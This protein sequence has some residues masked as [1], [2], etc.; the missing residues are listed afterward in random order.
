MK[1]ILFFTILHFG[2][3]TLNCFSQSKPAVVNT[4]IDSI[5]KLLLTAQSDTLKANAFVALSE[6]L[7]LSKID[8]VLPL[9]LKAIKISD[10]KLPK[11]DDAEKKSFLTAK[12]N[13]LNNMGYVYKEQGNIPK[14]LELY[15][16]SLKLREEIGDK[17]G[18]ANSLNNIGRIYNNRGDIPSALDCYTKSLRIQN[19][20]GDKQGASISLCNIGLIYNGQGDISKAL[21]YYNKGLKIQDEIGDK[22]GIGISLHNIGQVYSSQGDIPKA[23]EYYHKSLKILKE[24]GDKKGV[25]RSFNNIGGLFKDQGVSFFGS[26]VKEEYFIKALEYY[27]NGLKIQEELGEKE[28]IARTLNNIGFIYGM[29]AELETNQDSISSKYS[30]ALELN[31]KSLK[32]WQETGDKRGITN[33]L[34]NISGIYLKQYNPI[35]E[36]NKAA[37]LL[38]KSEE[39]CS[40]SLVYAK[41]LNYPE[42]IRNA[43]ERLS[44]IYKMMAKAAY[45][46][47][48]MAVAAEHYKQAMDMQ[49]LFKLTADKIN[50]VEAQKS[51]LKKQMQFEFEKKAG[52]AKA[53]QDKKDTEAKAE[54]QKQR[55]F[56]L[57]VLSGLAVLIVFTLFVYRSYRNKQKLNIELEK[58]SIVASETDNGVVICESDG[59]LEWI[60]DG[61]VRLLG[62]TLEEWK[63]RGNTVQEISHDPDINEKVNKSI[64]DKQTITYEALNITKDGR[65][66]WVHST[67]TPILDKQGNIK[68]LVVIDTDIT[69]R[70]QTENI[71]REK[72]REIT[73]S[74]YSAK[75]IQQALLASDTLLKKSLPEYFVLYKPKDIVSGDFYW[76][77]II[78]NKFVMITA[79]CTGHGVPG[80]FMSLLNISYLNEA[81][82]EKRIDSPEKILEY[83]RSQ[84]IYSLNPEGS[85]IESKD[86]MDAALCIY[87]FKNLWL[88]FACANNPLWILRN[89][90]LIIYKP[91]KMPVGMHYG[92]QK[93]FSLNTAGLRKGD[94]IYTFTDGY[95][96]QFGGEKG[97][98]YKYKALKKLLLSIQTKT[99]NEQ[100]EILNNTFENW[101]G[102]LE[103]VDDVLIIG[104]K[105]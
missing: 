30:K 78:D 51:L 99:M 44:I 2:L 104:I 75:R 56:L 36:K 40:Q 42:H 7:Y 87:D 20:I 88:R 46:S 85:I 70:K 92:E 38:N 4:K 59:T 14:A 102:S 10:E 3:L 72:N 94:I 22:Q 81:V 76:A 17:R 35:L 25:A 69:D 49:D 77:N 26:A 98:K 97:K 55:I 32:I 95:A 62:Y 105:V 5:Q 41:E 93:P 57:S 101:R 13:A 82:V 83:V 23:L 33:S 61:M 12:A 1:K 68:K 90:A 29:Q 53:E 58:L 64:A 79:D 47:G 65:K 74:I 6:E 96:D 8:T 9:C 86:G 15:N 54:Q 34:Y 31:Q 73:D 60:N 103:Q 21:E 100:K 45:N 48:L 24:T 66:L 19:E 91:D 71:I 52:M 50:D 80:A 63:E 89:N 43:S 39:F 18:I 11:A 37:I 16:Q 84:L 28:G 27:N 67:L